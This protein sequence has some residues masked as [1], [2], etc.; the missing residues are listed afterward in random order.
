MNLLRFCAFV[1]SSIVLLSIRIQSAEVYNYAEV[2]Q[3]S[4]WFYEV[5]RSGPLNPQTNRVEWRGSSAI[6]DGSD[7][8]VDLSGGWYDAGDN[9][10]FNFPM[11]SSVTLLAWGGLEN[12]TGYKKCGQWGYL[13]SN[14]KWVTDYL[15]K[16]HSAPNVFYSQIGIGMT[17]HKWWGSPEVFPNVRPAFKIDEAHPG[18][19]LAAEAAAALASSSML[20][21][22]GDAAYA[23]KLLQHAKELYDFA[24][25]YRGRYSDAITDAADFYK[26]WSGY[27]DELVWG[28]SWL[29]IAT[30]DTKY[31][32]KAEGLF[33]S[34][35]Y[36]NQTTIPKYKEALS[37]DDKT[38]G[39]YVLLAKITN[40]S[41]YHT[42]AQRWLDW[43]SHGYA[44]RQAGK[45]SWTGDS[46]IAYTPSGLAWIRSW[47]PIRYAANTAF[48]ALAYIKCTDVPDVKKKL[49]YNWAKSQIDYALGNNELKRSYVCGFGTNPPVKPHHRSMHGPYLDDNGRTPVN[50]RHVLY[51]ALVGGP[52]Q[53]G[54]Y[55]D[56]R[57]DAV[58]NEVATDYNAGFSSVLA[59]FVNDFNC[60]P[61][62][63]FPQPAERDT[64]YAVVAKINTPG[65]RFSEIS[66]TVEN[67]TTWPARYSK[68][69]TIRYF[70]DPSEVLNAGYLLKD[71][72]VEKRGISAGDS[73]ITISALKQYSPKPNLYYVEISFAGDTIFPGGQSQHRREVQFRIGLSDTFPQKLWDP[74]NDPSYSGLTSMIDSA[75][76]ANIPAYEDG[77]M[78]WGKEPDGTSFK[79]AKWNMPVFTEPQYPISEWNRT[80]LKGGDAVKFIDKKHTLK[81]P[82]KITRNGNDLSISAF[83]DLKVGVFTLDGRNIRSYS[84][85]RGQV[86]SIYLP[87]LSGSCTIIQIDNGVEKSNLRMISY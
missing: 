5:Q 68:N 81:S 23:D 79:P 34:L 29:Y 27:I 54:S 19:D 66:A 38:Y 18:S 45:T 2:L 52:S 53:D 11:S 21:R 73:G 8:G 57:L 69:L 83:S 31:L 43:W 30:G 72:N 76:S 80:I 58:R 47:G 50:S 42:C 40:K 4:M 44:A 51:G 61:L 10:K 20:F 62:P 71:I 56:D 16:C 35:G 48:A 28:A 77:V 37:W 82:F 7:A 78:V 33:D 1:V 22:A 65:D 24:D 49:Y 26:S 87:K 85:K 75:G 15:V 67:K 9:M 55:A 60:S 32:T 70:T 39:C 13:L 6:N 14:I 74:S 59:Q 25:K 36:E 17:D 41:K 12:A 3:K 64:E 46:G 84:F 86:S 63:N